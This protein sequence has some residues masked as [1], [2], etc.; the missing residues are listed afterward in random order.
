MAPAREDALVRGLLASIAAFRWVAWAWMAIVL[1]VSRGDLDDASGPRWLAIGLVVA[2][3]VVTAAAALLF[4][5][6]PPRLL[7]LPMIAVELALGFSLGAADG[8]VFVGD[9]APAHVDVARPRRL[10][11]PRRRRGHGTP[12]SRSVGNRQAPR[13]RRRRALRLSAPA[14]LCAKPP[15]APPHGRCSDDLSQ[16]NAA[17]PVTGQRTHQTAPPDARHRPPIGPPRVSLEPA[18]QLVRSRR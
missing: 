15:N 11:P 9:H 7:T 10:G 18:D 6:D 2:A 5:H 4:R 17:A 8:W 12:R 16:L 13:R 3:L 14:G 1:L